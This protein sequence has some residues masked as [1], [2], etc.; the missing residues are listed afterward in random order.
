MKRVERI[1]VT[2]KVV[3]CRCLAHT[4][5]ARF[6]VTTQHFQS[7]NLHLLHL[8][9]ASRG[10]LTI[11]RAKMAGPTQPVSID[12]RCFWVDGK[13][14]GVLS[15]RGLFVGLI[16]LLTS[17]VGHSSYRRGLCT[18]TTTEMGAQQVTRSLTMYSRTCAE[19]WR[20]S[21]SWGLTHSS[22]VSVGW[23]WKHGHISEQRQNGLTSRRPG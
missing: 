21:R 10:K 5:I 18:R 3:C 7:L 2:A 16:N 4:V 17:T 1:D 12:G 11:H 6:W 15:L 19:T 20:L 22:F 13:R 9:Q 23:G 14:V 8:F